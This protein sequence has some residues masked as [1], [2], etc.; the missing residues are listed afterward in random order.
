LYDFDTIVTGGHG[1][2]VIVFKRARA[3][4][5]VAGLVPGVLLG[6]LGPSST[7]AVAGTD[8]ATAAPA[9]LVH[10]SVHTFLGGA[11]AFSRTNAWT[12]GWFGIGSSSANSESLHW[13]G[14]KWALVKTVNE[15]LTVNGLEGISATSPS[16][17]WGVGWLF[18]NCFIQHYNGRNWSAVKCPYHGIESQLNGVSARTRTDAWAVGFVWP[19]STQIAFSEHWNGHTWA[20]VSTAPVTGSFIQL[21]SVLDLGPGNVLAVG[22][23]E[24]KSHGSYIHHQLAEHW[25][26]HAWRRVSVPGAGSASFLA[27]VSGKTS[28]GVTAVGAGTIGGHQVPLIERWTGSRFVRVAQPVGSGNLDAVTVLGKR[29]AYAVGQTGSSATL[30]EH[31]N[32]KRWSRVASPS[33]SDG[34]FLAAVAAV[35]S[36]A[37][38][39]AAGWHSPD[40]N[41][42]P[43]IEQG[44]GRR[45]RITRS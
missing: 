26:G 20:Q 40:P 32:G 27:G 28:T 25:N 30:V 34:S 2:E 31:Y 8:K 44:N 6:V 37:F 24:T 15:G 18:G 36:G 45:W 13:N 35:P 1:A 17:M 22:S 10:D 12:V 23:Y 11:I 7:A 41:E 39:V 21:A 3:L 5:A 19:E 38:V 42:N 29:N 43:L 16:N 14:R 33:P 4:L 9:A